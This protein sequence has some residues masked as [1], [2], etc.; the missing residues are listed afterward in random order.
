MSM[1]FKQV[2]TS[3]FN[4]QSNMSML[5]PCMMGMLL[6]WNIGRK[7]IIFLMEAVALLGTVNKLIV[8]LHWIFL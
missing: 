2:K 7:G 5:L 4:R 1:N 3:I 8:S 6:L